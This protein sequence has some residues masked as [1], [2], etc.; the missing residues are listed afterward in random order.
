MADKVTVIPSVRQVY[1][2][3]YANLPVA[4]LTAGDFGYATDRLVLYRWSGTAWDAISAHFSSG[5]YAA[6]PAVADLPEGSMYFATDRLVI[7]QVQAGP[8]WAS[9]TI[10]SAS[11]LA[12]NIPAAGDLPNGSIYF[13]T[14]TGL[15]QQVQAGAWASI[16]TAFDA[17]LPT[18]LTYGGAGAVGVAAAPAR[19]DHVHPLAAATDSRLLVAVKAADEIVN[20]SAVLQNDDHLVIALAAN[21]K[22]HVT[23]L[24]WALA[25][26]G[27][28]FKFAFTAPAACT[29]SR[30]QHNYDTTAG[31]NHLISAD[32]TTA[33]VAAVAATAVLIRIDAVVKN[34]ANA[35]NL[36]FQWAQNAAAAFN[37]TIYA[38]SSMTAIKLD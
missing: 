37:N 23:L 17:T 28:D 25:A 7:Y 3:V 20:N 13:E 35:G 38:G 2:D 9:I 6:L 14:D 21:K 26:N 32:L 15:F 34:G 5:L 10:Y 22:Y 18:A 30:L 11:G 19:R 12:A 8:A 4:G 27:D 24:L 1:Y 36:Q 16:G 31:N 29:G 33:M